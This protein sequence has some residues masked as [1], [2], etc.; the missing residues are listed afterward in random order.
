M[1]MTS[2]SAEE[3]KLSTPEI[4]SVSKL[5]ARDSVIHAGLSVGSSAGANVAWEFHPRLQ[6]ETSWGWRTDK[7]AG[8]L[9]AS[10]L[11]L[12]FPEAMGKVGPEARLVLYAGVGGQVDYVLDDNRQLRFGSRVSLGIK[13]TFADRRY[14]AFTAVATGLYYVPELRAS[15]DTSIGLRLRIW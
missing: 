8:W 15:L 10:D 3:N 7:Q 11:L 12:L 1:A 2:T 13:Y 9:G 14:E 5:K 4:T 6:W